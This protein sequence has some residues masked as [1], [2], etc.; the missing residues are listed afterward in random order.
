[1]IEILILANVVILALLIRSIKRVD[2]DMKESEQ[3]QADFR[4]FLRTGEDYPW[5][6]K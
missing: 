2:R 6:K 1:M 5:S 3:I 4:E